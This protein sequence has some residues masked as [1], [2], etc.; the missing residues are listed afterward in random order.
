MSG[1]RKGGRRVMWRRKGGRRREGE[2]GE[3]G[4]R[5]QGARGSFVM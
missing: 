5:V 3:G 2:V 4:G 1:G